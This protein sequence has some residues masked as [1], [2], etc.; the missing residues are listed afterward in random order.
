QKEGSGQSDLHSRCLAKPHS[1]GRIE[2]KSAW[3]DQFS[4]STPDDIVVSHCRRSR[5]LLQCLG[6][7][8]ARR[9]G[10]LLILLA[11]TNARRGSQEA[12]KLSPG[13]VA[14]IYARQIREM[15]CA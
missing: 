7:L 2:Q 3:L 6:R 15:E 4:E 11:Y 9:F 14:E 8:L 1:F 12:K 13:F 10:L 5:G